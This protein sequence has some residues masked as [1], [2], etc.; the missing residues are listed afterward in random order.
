MSDCLHCIP[1]YRG[2]R[3]LI[4]GAISLAAVCAATCCFADGLVVFDPLNY[5]QSVLTAMRSLQQ[6][7]IEVENL[8]KQTQM[9]INS[10]K[11]LMRAPENIAEQLQANTNEIIHLMSQASGLTFKVNMTVNQFQS[12]YPI[13]YSSGTSG[14]RFEQDASVR[15][16]NTYEAL[17][18][19]LLLQ[20]QAV[21]SLNHDGAN[22]AAAMGRSSTAI[23]SLQAQ[24]ANNELLSLQVKQGMQ[25]QALVA[26]QA[27]AN[28]LRDAEWMASEAVAAE[29]FK[30]FIG[31]GRAYAGGR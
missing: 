4:K 17:G 10:T 18:E 30:Q 19:A 22:L 15:R 2:R 11:N 25:N 5:N 13:Q 3:S 6:I 29:R 1:D 20:S 8:T 14:S 23:G 24:Q 21:E 12:T 27:R 9:L 26:A 16:S 7:N 31:N 28:A